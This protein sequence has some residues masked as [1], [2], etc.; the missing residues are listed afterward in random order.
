MITGSDVAQ[1]GGLNYVISEGAL[2]SRE[3][4]GAPIAY[5]VKYLKDNR[6]AKMGYNTDYRLE[7]CNT[8]AYDHESLDVDNNSIFDIRFRF[9]YKSRNGNNTTVGGYTTVNNGQR[10]VVSP[11]NGAHDV[12]VEFQFQ[13][14]FVWT[15]F[16][17][18]KSYG[19]ISSQKCFEITNDGILQGF[20]I[21]L[22]PVSCN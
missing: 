16:G 1:S 12:K 5:T 10:K 15:K 6:V 20:R 7:T 21:Y 4:P 22:T 3:N 17:D 18:T 11:P 19:Y 2:Y 13:D 8:Y 14:A 9:I